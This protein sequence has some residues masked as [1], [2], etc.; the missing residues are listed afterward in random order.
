MPVDGTL[1]L[2]KFLNASANMYMSLIYY[3]KSIPEFNNLPI[4]SKLSLI[5][6]NLNQICRIHS[7]L[8]MK[9]VTPDLDKDSPVFLHIFPKELYFEIRSTSSALIPFVH[10]PL[11]IKLFLT[12]LM[13]STHMN[14]EY[15]KN[16]IEI[17]NENFTRNIFNVQ[18][19]YI[20][21]LWR[22]IRSRYS[23]YRQSVLLLTSFITRTL[24]SQLVQEKMNKFVRTI[25]PSESQSLEPIIKS[26][27]ISEK[28]KYC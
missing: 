17:N 11:L 2:E 28:E 16:Q 25:L 13:L 22:Y 21:L 12:V 23:N 1:T 24:Y 7:T 26:V 20:E 8:I 5:K 6:S 18:N 10:D 27:W 14:I 4:Q 3:L 15:E 19:I 9:I